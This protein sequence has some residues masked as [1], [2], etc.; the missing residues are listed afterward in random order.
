MSGVDR[1][2]HRLSRLVVVAAVVAGVVVFAAGAGAPAARPPPR[3]RRR[4]PRTARRRSAG[5][6]PPGRRGATRTSS[7]APN[8]HVL[9][10]AVVPVG[11]TAG[12]PRRRLPPPS[13]GSPGT[14]R[15][16]RSSTPTTTRTPPPTSPP[17]G[18]QFGLPAAA[19]AASARSNQTRR[20]RTY[21]TGDTGWGAE[22]DLDIEMV[23]AACPSLQHPARRG[24]HSKLRRPDAAVD[25]AAGHANYVS[26]S[27]GGERVHHRDAL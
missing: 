5:A 24:R 22:I 13:T 3:T 18:P 4:C 7:P 23:A 27:Y 12:R 14:G 9:W 17:T 15:P 6:R 20:A 11:C 21:P 25:Y 26:N 8:G 19:A 1:M 10:P 2:R 16:S